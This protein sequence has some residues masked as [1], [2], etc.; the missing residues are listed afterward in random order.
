MKI[1]GKRVLLTGATGGIGQAIARRLAGEGAELV[2]TGRNEQ[3]LAALG[4]DLNAR[5]I[6]CDLLKPDD[7][8][9]LVDEAGAVDILVANA[10]LPGT[11][12]LTR[13]S[14]N[15]IGC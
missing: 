15:A 10:G 7:V 11:A 13:F 12:P 4:K 3:T 2:L 9:R 1:Q 6:A 14:F 8:R 5:I